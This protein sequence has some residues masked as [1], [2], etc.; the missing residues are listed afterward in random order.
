MFG[1]QYVL[2]I[3]PMHSNR[4]NAREER[5]CRGQTRGSGSET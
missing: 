2:E 3:I 4:V 5:E 1:L